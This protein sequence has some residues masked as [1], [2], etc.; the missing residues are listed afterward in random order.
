[1]H[2]TELFSI[3]CTPL[4]KS[5]LQKQ[6]KH[7]YKT[8]HTCNNIKHKLLKKSCLK[9][10]LLKKKKKKKKKKKNGQKQ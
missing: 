6:S 9:S 4:L 7:K 10:P 3:T 1:M 5:N 2:V 8:K